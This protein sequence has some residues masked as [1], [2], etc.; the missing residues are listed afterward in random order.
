MIKHNI[1]SYLEK[2]LGEVIDKKIDKIVKEKMSRK[3]IYNGKFES[4]LL[5]NALSM[6]SGVFKDTGTE[7]FGGSQLQMFNV[8][9]TEITRSIKRN[10]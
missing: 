3:N 7:I 1:D 6:V 5:S 8:F 9:S 4:K 2:K 10:E